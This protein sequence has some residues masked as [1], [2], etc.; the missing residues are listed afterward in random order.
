MVVLF[1]TALWHLNMDILVFQ[2]CLCSCLNRVNI[3][4]EGK[5]GGRGKI[6]G[7]ILLRPNVED[8]HFLK[9]LKNL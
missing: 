9:V 5:W 7:L 1:L 3:F 6:F 2:E 4:H 8:R